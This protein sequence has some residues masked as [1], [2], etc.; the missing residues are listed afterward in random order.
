MSALQG[1]RLSQGNA[2]VYGPGAVWFKEEPE[3]S[4]D[5]TM[6]L[7]KSMIDDRRWFDPFPFD[8]RVERPAP[9]D[10]KVRPRNGKAGS[11]DPDWPKKP[12]RHDAD[13]VENPLSKALATA[14][15]GVSIGS[16]MDSKKKK[17]TK[18]TASKSKPIINQGRHDG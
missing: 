9:K 18:K 17:S 7:D 13:L 14:T 11:K 8:A 5:P 6:L 4:F 16:K 12:G 1:H 15:L 10:R 2:P 3:T